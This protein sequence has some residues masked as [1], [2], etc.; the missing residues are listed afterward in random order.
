[1]VANSAMELFLSEP[2]YIFF[3]LVRNI[4]FPLF[5]YGGLLS[6]YFWNAFIHVL[7]NQASSMISLFYIP[8]VEVSNSELL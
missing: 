7:Q 4:F 6:E 1:M 2:K 5:I 3:Q 8:L